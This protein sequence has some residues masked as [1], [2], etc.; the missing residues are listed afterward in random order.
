VTGNGSIR[1]VGLRR[2]LADER[3]ADVF[4]AHTTLDSKKQDLL[5]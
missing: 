5:P 3:A 2:V 4:S 1:R